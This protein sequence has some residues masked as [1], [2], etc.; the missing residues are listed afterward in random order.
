M[1]LL[2]ILMVVYQSTITSIIEA[3]INRFTSEEV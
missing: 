1:V 3:F 2:V